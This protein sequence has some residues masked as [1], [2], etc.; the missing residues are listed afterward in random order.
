MHR[1]DCIVARL[2]GRQ[3]RRDIEE[4]LTRIKTDAFMTCA[5]TSL[6]NL[7]RRLV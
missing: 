1:R 2:T 6:P 3:L 4:R 5:R 7:R